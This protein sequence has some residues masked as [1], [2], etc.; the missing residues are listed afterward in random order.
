M[1]TTADA[2]IIGGGVM[3]CSILYNLASL[4]MTNTLLLE[5]DVLGSGSTSRSQ[6]IL[7]MHYS[8]EV[9]SLFAW[10]SLE[11]LKNFEELTGTPSGYTRTGYFL[12]VSDEDDKKAMRDNVAM[13]K[14]LGIATD[15][16]TIEQAREIAPMVSFRDD[17]AFAYE[18]ESGYADPYSVTTGYANRARDMG[19][20]VKDGTMV[21]DIEITGG[22]VTAIV[23][24]DERIETPIAVVA[25][26]PWSRPLLRKVGLDLPLGTVRHQVINLR[27]PNN[28]PEHPAI[29]DIANDFSTRPDIGMRTLIGV[30]EEDSPGPDEYNQGLDMPAVESGMVRLA[31]RIPAMSEALFQGGWSGLFT[32]TPDWHQI[33]DKVEG[34]DGLYCA[35][36]FS[37]HGF[38]ESPMIGLTMAE[39]I[40]QGKASTI[41]I[42]MLNMQRFNEGKLMRSRYTMQVLA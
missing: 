16:V 28:L 2:V 15:E 3:G 9:T 40:T 13:H 35:V 27:R 14:G 30:G 31:K 4:G 10:K 5:K 8:N 24:P 12:I 39:L 29:G 7:R 18:P 36:G 26:G 23:T 38:K 33:L 32:T 20:R 1:A 6:A 37:G 22:K 19:A 42:S 34:I 17:E 11:V 25:T 41:D 21:T